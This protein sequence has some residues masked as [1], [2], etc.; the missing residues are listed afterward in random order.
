MPGKIPD[1][2]II[3]G[4]PNDE[5]VITS[6]TVPKPDLAVLEITFYRNVDG[7]REDEVHKVLGFKLPSVDNSKLSSL[8]PWKPGN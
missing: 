2:I 7:K 1:P 8:V 3:P 5:L 6:Y 4:D